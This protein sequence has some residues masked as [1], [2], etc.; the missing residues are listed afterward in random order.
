MSDVP[1]EIAALDEMQRVNSRARDYDDGLMCA[2]SRR[3]R[4]DWAPEHM[5]TA[6]SARRAEWRAQLTAHQ[7]AAVYDLREARAQLRRG[8]QTAARSWS[9]T[10]GVAHL[11]RLAPCYALVCPTLAMEAPHAP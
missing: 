3:L 7:E 9:E 6:R 4:P 1:R 8:C 10:A 2:A 11:A 5:T